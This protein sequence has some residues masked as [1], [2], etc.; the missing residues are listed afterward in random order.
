MEGVYSVL[1]YQTSYLQAWAYNEKACKNSKGA[2]EKDVRGKMDSIGILFL[3]KREVSAHEVIKK[4]W[5]LLLRPSNIIDI[6]YV[7]TGPT[8]PENN[9]TR[10]LKPRSILEKVQVEDDANVFASTI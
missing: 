8:G 9:W 2:Y 7:P 10:I 6:L 1:T 5:S 4:V 3:T